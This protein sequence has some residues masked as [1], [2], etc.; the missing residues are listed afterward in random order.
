VNVK[1]D[2]VTCY[3]GACRFVFVLS[4]MGMDILKV[5][6]ISIL[7]AVIARR[8]WN[9]Y[10]KPESLCGRTAFMPVFWIRR[11]ERSR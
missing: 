10:K 3:S 2:I 9:D 7:Y 5:I 1:I 6:F 4:V 8:Y 11:E